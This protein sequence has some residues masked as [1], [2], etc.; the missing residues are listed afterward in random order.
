MILIYFLYQRG[1]SLPHICIL[2]QITSI[3]RTY[4]WFWHTNLSER[5][6]FLPTCPNMAWQTI[7]L[8]ILSSTCVWIFHKPKTD[9]HVCNLLVNTAICRNNVIV[10]L[11]YRSGVVFVVCFRCGCSRCFWQLTWWAGGRFSKKGETNDCSD[12]TTSMRHFIHTIARIYNVIG[13]E[14]CLNV[15]VFVWTFSGSDS[16]YM[17]KS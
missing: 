15:V 10:R 14:A 7:Q 9:A 8:L 6:S 3:I 2:I 1:F 16:R 17:F 11:A 5:Y 12:V 4:F 13:S